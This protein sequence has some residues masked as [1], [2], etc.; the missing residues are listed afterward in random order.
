MLDTCTIVTE[1]AEPVYD[2]VT[3]TYTFDAAATVY[4]G[5]CKV[6]SSRAL[7][8]T[9]DAGEQV[10]A[11]SRR[12]MHLPVNADSA[13]VRPRQVVT[14]TAS[15]HN[16]GLVGRKFLLTDLGDEKSM[17]TARRYGIEEA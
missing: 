17:A 8:H 5:P 9:A 13:D 7:A 6:Q 3:D 2:P 11:V 12:E 4:S 15:A 14:I 10:V 16:A 1:D